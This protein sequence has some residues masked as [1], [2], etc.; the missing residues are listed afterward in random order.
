ML[1]VSRTTVSNA[2]SRPEQLSAQ[3]RDRILRAAAKVGYPG[4][5]LAAASLRTG[6]TNTLGVLFTDSLS[7]AFSDPV[8]ARF[9]SGVATEAETGGYALTIVSAPGAA[10]PVRCRRRSSTGS[11]S[12]RWTT[13]RLLW[14]WRA[15]AGSLRTVS[16]QPV[17]GGLGWTV[18]ALRWVVEDRRPHGTHVPRIG[19]TVRSGRQGPPAVM[20]V[21]LGARL[22]HARPPSPRAGPPAPDTRWD[23]RPASSARAARSCS[24]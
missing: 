20:A 2:F 6:L 7:Y 24:G 3:L 19:S 15:V 13:T 1:G 4:P 11:S 12:I 8:S 5:D 16:C 23:T 14:T 17:A 18:Y 21:R 9:L 22:M 10:R